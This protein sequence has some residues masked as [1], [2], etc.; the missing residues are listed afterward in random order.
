MACAWGTEG[1]GELLDWLG[2]PKRHQVSRDSMLDTRRED[3]DLHGLVLLDLPDHD[4][5]E[6]SHHVEVDR[7]VRLTDMLVWVLDPQK[8]ADAAIHDR[9]LHPL[10]RHQDVMLVVLNHID[11]VPA[12]RRESMVGD[13]RR[14]LDA[15]GLDRVPVLTASARHGEGIVELKRVIAE[16]VSRKQATKARLLADVTAAAERLH[17][18]S[19][20][21]R[22]GDVARSRKAELVDAFADAAGDPTVVEAVG[23]ATRIRA[24]RATGWPVVSWLSRLRPD[25]LR[26]LHLDQ[27]ADG[28]SLVAAARSSIPEA[29]QVQHARVDA[30]VRGV[31]DDASQELPR[32]WGQAVRRASVSRLDDL[33]D[34]L[35]RAVAQ[36]DLGMSRTPGWWQLMRVLQW[37][38][39]LG[40]LAGAVWLAVLAVLGYLQ[41][42]APQAPEY[43]G[44]PVP[45]LLLLGGVVVGIVLALL[46]RVLAGWSARLRARAAQRRLRAAIAEVTEELVVAPIETEIDAYRATRDGIAAALR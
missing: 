3:S 7:L 16:R 17:E 44:L 36:T 15:D 33:N 21:A 26:R 19:G 23:K 30:A 43:A 2:V 31:A 9:Y 10:A 38:L 25:P 46:S 4:S 22:P 34:A 1:A 14:L 20:D 42:P 5:T 29:N 28:R 40:A 41:L 35:D 11:T 32:P 24:G 18:V 12:D 37:L 13:L 45:T 27:G 39:M 8:Y 6:V